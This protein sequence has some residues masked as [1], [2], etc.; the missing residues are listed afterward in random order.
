MA[1]DS[2][3]DTETFLAWPAETYASHALARWAWRTHEFLVALLLV[4]VCSG[5]LRAV[6][7]YGAVDNAARLFLAPAAGAYV[8]AAPRLRGAATMLLLQNASILTSASAAAAALSAGSS[9][10]KGSSS[11]SDRDLATLA[12]VVVAAGALSGVGSAGAALAVEREWPAA[13][14]ASAASSAAEDGRRSAFLS[15]VNSR[16]RAIDL[17]CQLLAPVLAGALMAAL[18]GRAAALASAGFCACAW[19][20]QAL[21]LRSAVGRSAALSRPKACEAEVA[22]EEEAGTGAA[23]VPPAGSGSGSG[24]LAAWARQGPLAAPALSLALL[25]CTVLSLG[26][27][28]TAWLKTEGLTEAAIAGARGA[29]ALSGI[30]AALAFPR[31]A[32]ALAARD[33]GRRRRDGG[34]AA[35]GL[36]GIA[37]QLSALLVGV[38]PTVIA[39][40][41]AGPEAG[42]AAALPAG[43]AAAAPPPARPPSPALALLLPG[44]VASRAGLW[45]FDLA[46]TLLQQQGVPPADQAK[47][48]GAQAALQSGFEL[49]SFVLAALLWPQPAQFWRPMALSLAAVALAAALYGWWWWWWGAFGRPLAVGRAA[50]EGPGV[51]PAGAAP[52]A[53]A[54]GRAGKEEEE[55]EEESR[56]ALLPA[57]AGRR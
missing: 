1:R 19:G 21:L 42:G 50:G 27:M 40:A 25:Y 6:A 2:D 57:E 14:A 55:E 44:L 53:A 13:V 3:T 23:E 22:G 30:G 29:G 28:M 7:V 32:A 45:T 47:V 17:G 11:S 37:L 41:A 26:M 43:S 31:V 54:A 24:S 35:A 18:G 4:E 52:A 16:M 51:E 36:V 46:V 10:S 5:S 9:S 39:A 56:R 48:G 20:P 38:L 49:L 33:D 8:D 12:A 34:V 15:R